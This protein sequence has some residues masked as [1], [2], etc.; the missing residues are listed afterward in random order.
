[1]KG[2]ADAL[3]DLGETVSSR[4]LVLNL[5]CCLNER[6]DHLRTWIVGLFLSPTSRRSGM[7][8]SF[9][10]PLRGSR[11]LPP[12]HRLSTASV[13]VGRLSTPHPPLLPLGSHHLIHLP[14]LALLPAMVEVTIVG[15]SMVVVA[16]LE[17]E[18]VVLA[19]MAHPGHSSA[20]CGSAISL[21][22]SVRHFVAP[23]RSHCHLILRYL[24]LCLSAVLGV[25]LSPH[26]R[27]HRR[28]TGP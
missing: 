21:C 9:R 17:A 25:R 6:Y 1:M 7:T 15:T 18:M 2:M 11:F 3:C 27:L 12:P 5:L 20:T 8:S 22:N 23:H 16:A 24:P 28:C 19:R 26:L 14:P 13:P 10:S 4:T